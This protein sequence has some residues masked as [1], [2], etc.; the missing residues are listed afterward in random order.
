MEHLST[1]VREAV[2]A[3]KDDADYIF[4][5]PDKETITLEDVIKIFETTMPDLPEKKWRFIFRSIDKDG[6][7]FITQEEM[8][9]FLN[10]EIEDVAGYAS[11]IFTKSFIEKK[12][13]A[14]VGL[15][16]AQESPNKYLS[17]NVK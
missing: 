11:Q 16:M 14:T 2:I 3:R 6:S 4:W 1:I 9:R 8:L 5:P 17:A 7:G 15:V 12:L 10:L 13:S